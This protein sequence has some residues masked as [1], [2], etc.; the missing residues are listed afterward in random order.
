MAKAGP[1]TLTMRI[2]ALAVDVGAIAGD[3]D[4]LA[5]TYRE[6]LT[7]VCH[8]CTASGRPVFARTATARLGELI[9]DW[10][11]L[12]KERQAV[13]LEVAALGRALMA[14]DGDVGEPEP[15]ATA[16]LKPGVPHAPVTG[17]AVDAAE[18]VGKPGRI[19]PP[20]PP[21]AAPKARGGRK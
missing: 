12:A 9:D 15:A 20:A 4:K 8:G 6:I 19:E 18:L 7:A 5:G 13:A 10:L 16:T 14:L 3:L 2:E 11:K 17:G 21:A 1:L